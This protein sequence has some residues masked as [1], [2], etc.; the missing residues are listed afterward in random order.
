MAVAYATFPRFTT[1]IG[2]L[3]LVPSSIAAPHGFRLVAQQHWC[4]YARASVSAESA[5]ANN[6]G[7]GRGWRPKVAQEGVPQEVFEDSKFV[8]IKDADPR[9]GPPAMLLLGFRHEEIIKVEE[10]LK[11]IHGEFLKILL[12]TK[13]MI[14]GTLWD[15]INSTQPN[16][17]SV[18]G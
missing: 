16:L 2:L 11:E 17:L 12:C 13:E 3:L 15:A 9:F 1:Q 7:Q 18:E 10:F 14:T 5:F 4:S 6:Q 8:Q